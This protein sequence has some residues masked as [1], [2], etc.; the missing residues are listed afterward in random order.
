L[1]KSIGDAWF[2]KLLSVAAERQT[3][4]PS[5]R[6]QNH[7]GRNSAVIRSPVGSAIEYSEEGFEKSSFVDGRCLR[8]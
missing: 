7:R 8:L 4:G 6:W 5:L 2:K 1:Q 3:T